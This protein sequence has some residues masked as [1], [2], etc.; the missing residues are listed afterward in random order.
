MND[1]PV[2]MFSDLDATLH[3]ARRLVEQ[4]QADLA[5]RSY[6][7]V[8]EFA[9]ENTE[10]LNYLGLQALA[11]QQ[12][13][14]A[15]DF[16]VHA[17][18]LEPANPQ[19]QSNLGLAYLSA[20]RYT[21][22]ASVFERTLQVKPKFF[23]A[24]LHYAH[25]LEQLGRDH[26][27][28]VNYF[29]AISQAQAKG[30]WMS[31]ATTAP[32]LRD[33]VKYAMRY[34]DAG[35]KQLFDAVLTPLRE[36]Y[37]EAA[38]IRAQRCLDMYLGEVPIVYPDARQRPNFL[39]FPDLPTSTYF[40]RDLFPWYPALEAQMQTIREELFAVLGDK[41]GLEPFL[42]FDSPADVPRYLAGGEQG[43]PTWDAFFFY[44]HGVRN[45]ENCARCP[46]TSAIL[47]A[48][49]LVRIPEHAPEVCFSVLTPGTHILK[50]RGVTNTRLVTHLPLVVPADC[51]IS[52]G[53]ELHA[54][55]EGRCVTFDDTFEHEAWNRSEQTRVVMLLDTWN[56]HLS[57][58]EC[59]AVT[60]LVEAIGDFN[61]E[62]G[63][64]TV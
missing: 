30:R 42:K 3:N 4:G 25:A 49:P 15:I 54:W 34:V 57:S 20:S 22:A 43:A 58:P 24:R 29:T 36:R 56:P 53:G 52:V 1:T 21:A 7:R 28:L 47:D 27:A 11:A 13:D 17:A 33:L 63:L 51:A 48:L 6:A 40:A 16:L 12:T 9:P 31:D 5:G 59:E 37:G 10:A 64:E 46:R 8:L 35:R 2:P 41:S 50:H 19:L 38:M 55:Q 26:A 23:V 61:R 44:R 62:C 45:D 18:A 60:A 32:I 39:Y 14:Q